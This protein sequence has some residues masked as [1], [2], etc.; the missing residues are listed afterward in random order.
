MDLLEA[1]DNG[2]LNRVK[3]LIKAG[4]DLEIQD[5]D[6]Q[7]PLTTA[8]NNCN[9]DIVEELVLC[10][11]NVDRKV[12]GIPMIMW[13]D[14]LEMIKILLNNGA[15]PNATNEDYSENALFVPSRW[16]DVEIIEELIAAGINVNAQNKYG[17]TPLYE[18]ISHLNLECVK[19]LLEAGANPNILTNAKQ[20]PLYKIRILKESYID[21]SKK[22]KILELLKQH[23][24]KE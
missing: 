8:M 4:A 20:S 10:G 15:D 6:E 23:G 13:T 2:D 24:A 1:C 11:A 14:H 17:H 21:S 19:V 7:T 18:A 22:N 16:K 3:K 5:E 12:Y 9:F